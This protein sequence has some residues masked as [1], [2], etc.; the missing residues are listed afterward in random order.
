MSATQNQGC[1]CFHSEYTLQCPRH[2][3]LRGTGC[4]P[5]H[6]RSSQLSELPG[7]GTYTLPS[8]GLRCPTLGLSLAVTPGWEPRGWAPWGWGWGRGHRTKAGGVAVESAR[9]QARLGPRDVSAGA[10]LTC[11]PFAQ[12]SQP[13][14][15]GRK[16]KSPSSPLWVSQADE[17]SGATSKPKDLGL[18]GSVHLLKVSTVCAGQLSPA[19]SFM[20]PSS[21]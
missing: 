2:S 1:N 18:P 11:C 9:P 5:L 14:P 15:E 12:A 16:C 7:P 10:C 13:S 20:L 6:L 21:A 4:L 17:C 8:L 19:V 3:P